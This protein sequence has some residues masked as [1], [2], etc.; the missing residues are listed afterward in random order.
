MGRMKVNRRVLM[1]GLGGVMAGSLLT[2]KA[3]AGSLEP[4]PGGVMPTGRSVQDLSDKIGRTDYGVSEPRI[5]VKSLPGSATASHCIVT[6]GSYYVTEN[7]LGVPGKHGIEIK[8]DN[9]DLDLCGFHLIGPPADPVG[10]APG[11]AI[12]TDRQNVTVYNGTVLV[13]GGAVDFEHASLFILWDISSIGALGSAFILG[14]CGQA[15]DCD[16]YSAAVAGF[17]A[18]GVRSLVEECGTWSCGVGFSSTGSQNLFLSNCATDCATPFDISPGNSHG[19]FVDVTGVG[20]ISAVP[21]SGR[22]DS[23]LIY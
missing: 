21:N 17:S 14:N 2:G 1:T 12:V 6:P 16:A 11:S 5:P 9:V 7:L 4:P 15:Y 8:S 18:P 3:Q 22:P 13:W 23:N 20:D 10:N 19:P